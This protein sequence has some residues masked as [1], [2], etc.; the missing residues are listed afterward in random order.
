MDA[1]FRF[2]VKRGKTTQLLKLLAELVSSLEEDA[3]FINELHVA[4]D[5]ENGTVPQMTEE[6]RQIADYTEGQMEGN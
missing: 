1:D 2:V 5:F 3:V 6:E 4:F